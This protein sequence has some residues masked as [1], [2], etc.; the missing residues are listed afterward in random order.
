MGGFQPILILTDH[1]ALESWVS[2]HVDTPS[3]PAGGRAR[4]HETLSKFDI[5]EKYVPGSKNIVADAM[6]RN[7]YL[8]SRALQ[9][10]SWHGSLKDKLEMEKIMA[11]EFA[12]ERLV[13]LLFSIRE[14]GENSHGDGKIAP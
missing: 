13:G 8:A 7:A 9:D 1:K 10:C 12:E 3:G 11:E 14:Q 4:W 2:E 5:E 6:S